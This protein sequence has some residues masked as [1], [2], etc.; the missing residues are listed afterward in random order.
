VMG[1]RPRVHL[2]D[3]LRETIEWFRDHHG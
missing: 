1:F 3:G 2:A